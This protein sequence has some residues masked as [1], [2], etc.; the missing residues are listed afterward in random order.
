MAPTDPILSPRADPM[1]GWIRT[2]ATLAATLA[3]FAVLT[4]I[5]GVTHP[6]PGYDILPDPAGALGF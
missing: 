4:A 2:L 6:G 1:A 3:A 5:F